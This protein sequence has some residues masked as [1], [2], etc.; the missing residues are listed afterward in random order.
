MTPAR[1][2]ERVDPTRAIRPTRRDEE[3]PPR[4]RPSPPRPSEPRRAPEPDPG[5][6]VDE[7]AR[8]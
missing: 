2:P 1:G 8:A 6:R 7:Y 5:R 3:R 4:G